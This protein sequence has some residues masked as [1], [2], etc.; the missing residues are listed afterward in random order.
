VSEV[1]VVADIARAAA[2]LFLESTAG[3]AAARGRAAVALTGGSSAAPLYAEL[4]KNP[5]IPWRDLQIFFTDE[6]AV[7]PGDPLSNFGVAERELLVHIPPCA[8][9]RLRGEAPDLGEE[10]RRATRELRQTLGEMPR[11]D[12]MLLGLGPDG[13]ILSLFAGVPG[14]AE[15]GDE[16]LVR[17]VKAPEQVEPKVARLTLTPFLLLTARMVVLQVSGA[18]KAGVLARTLEGPDDLVGC[19]AQWLRHAAGRV[20]VVCDEAAAADL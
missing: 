7:P 2:E 6:R 13:H 8:V 12:L 20:V 4:R 3:A 15:R 16:D 5:K 9:H 17:H 19:P 14:S 11:L 18:K 10:A 1:A